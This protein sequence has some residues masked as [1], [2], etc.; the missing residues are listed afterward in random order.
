MSVAPALSETKTLKSAKLKATKT[1]PVSPVV[2]LEPEK[3][4]VTAVKKQKKKANPEPVKHTV[5]ET[6][7][8]EENTEDA[9]ETESIP[10]DN[11][12]APKDIIIIRADALK[13][14]KALEERLNELIR[15]IE[16]RRSEDVLL[17]KELR[18]IRETQ[19]RQVKNLVKLVTMK[20]KKLFKRAKRPLV[21]GEEPKLSALDKPQ[22]ISDEMCDFIGHPR[23]SVLPR[24]EVIKFIR[25]YIKQNKLQDPNDGRV[26]LPN[27]ALER[28]F[29]GPV[30]EVI[31]HFTFQRYLVQH[32]PECKK[33]KNH[34][35][36]RFGISP[37]NDSSS[38]SSASIGV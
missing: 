17:I 35:L 29:G 32:F 36:E 18:Y 14:G 9:S 21:E 31:T 23:G 13:D 27:D 20:N 37:P 10:K 11:V 25:S 24:K 6:I 34:M 38:S 8:V 28:I 2:T 26:L 4:S 3:E 5:A 22:L 12:D 15:K 33:Y 7:Q 19:S 30:D 1:K 16:L